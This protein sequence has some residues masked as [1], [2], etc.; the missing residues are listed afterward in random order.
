[1]FISINFV[2]RDSVWTQLMA[3]I[4]WPLDKARQER[5]ALGAAHN[6]CMQL[7]QMASSTG[8]NKLYEQGT[9]LEGTGTLLSGPWHIHRP[10]PIECQPGG[11]VV[12]MISTVTKALM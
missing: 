2:F 10:V 8:L 5:L 7:L 12:R 3:K 11:L 9:H 6:T 4:P 1:V